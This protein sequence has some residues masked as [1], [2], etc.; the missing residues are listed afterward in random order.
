MVFVKEIRIFYH[1]DFDKNHQMTVKY[2]NLEYL[3]GLIG[4]YTL[5]GTSVKNLLRMHLCAGSTEFALTGL[6]SV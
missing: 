3:Q 4:N 2:A 6:K 1:V 5:C